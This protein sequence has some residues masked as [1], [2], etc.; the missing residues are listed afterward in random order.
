MMV[1]LC[2]CCVGVQLLPPSCFE[3]VSTDPLQDF[4][5][6]VNDIV[7]VLDEY[8]HLK[9]GQI[10]VILCFN[11]KIKGVNIDSS[12]AGNT[13]FACTLFNEEAVVKY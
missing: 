10:T 13:H 8:N 1:M 5:Q 7:C 9:Y 11:M 4:R 3:T 6:T 2:V 12:K